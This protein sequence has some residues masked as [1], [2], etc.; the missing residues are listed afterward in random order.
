MKGALCPT[1]ILFDLISISLGQEIV[2]RATSVDQ[3]RDE[4]Q[5][6][7]LPHVA[8]GIHFTQLIKI[9]KEMLYPAEILRF[10]INLT[11]LE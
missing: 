9:M 11:K 3:S 8:F 4:S 1:D 5:S 10:D 6:F 2:A 7:F